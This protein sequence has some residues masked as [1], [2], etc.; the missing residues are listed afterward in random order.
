MVGVGVIES[1]R[2]QNFEKIVWGQN[3]MVGGQ[4]FGKSDRGSF[5]KK[6]VGVKILEKVVGVG[7]MKMG[8]DV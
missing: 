6:M 2:G 3:K 8:G 7:K 5:E 1:G 4:N